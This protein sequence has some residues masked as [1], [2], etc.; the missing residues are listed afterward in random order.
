MLR[1]WRMALDKNKILTKDKLVLTDNYDHIDFSNGHQVAWEF[2]R[3]N[4][5]YYKAY[6]KV[7]LYYIKLLNKKNK[8][9]LSIEDFRKKH[10]EKK[11]NIGPLFYSHTNILS[12]KKYKQMSQ[13]AERWNLADFYDPLDYKVHG[14]PIKIDEKIKFCSP[15]LYGSSFNINMG[16]TEIKHNIPAFHTGLLIDMRKSIASQIE[17]AKKYLLIN[18]EQIPK[19]F[20]K[21]EVMHF[22]TSDSELYKKYLNIIDLLIIDTGSLDIKKHIYKET[23]GYINDKY[24]DDKKRALQIVSYDYKQFINMNYETYPEWIDKYKQ[25]KKQLLVKQDNYFA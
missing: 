13:I 10:Q 5:S 14:L 3:R 22:R 17:H 20:L 18:Q 15:F 23:G 25:Q 19:N 4:K 7:M 6:H 24:K 9:N 16:N 21:F 8:T 11:S 1:G 12:K 2:L